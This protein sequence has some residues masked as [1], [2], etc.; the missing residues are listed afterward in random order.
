METE[1]ERLLD[2]INETKKQLEHLQLLGVEGI[3]PSKA[4][5]PR[6]AVQ[7]PV[8]RTYQPPAQQKTQ[9]VGNSLFGELGLTPQNLTPSSETFEEIHTEI[10]DCTRC[11]LHC[12][13]T[14]VVH[15]EAIARHV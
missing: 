2:L 7:A 9:V 8:E 1:S 5:T 12:E 11:P 14:H 10:G 6:V 15:T 4:T 13:R 3:Q